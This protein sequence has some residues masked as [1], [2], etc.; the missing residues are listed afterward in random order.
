[1]LESTLENIRLLSIKIRKTHP[2]CMYAPAAPSRLSTRYAD[3]TPQCGGTGLQV[4]AGIAHCTR[5]C[6]EHSS[7]FRA[8]YCIVRSPVT[9]GASMISTSLVRY[10]C[11][12]HPLFIET[13]SPPA[14]RYKS[15]GELMGLYCASRRAQRGIFKL[16]VMAACCLASICRAHVDNVSKGAHKTKQ[17]ISSSM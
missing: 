4:K 9:P 17:R 8:V 6:A 15:I 7:R 5:E 14:Q 13:D 12:D 11:G 3:S 16:R 1:M 2:A 10:Y